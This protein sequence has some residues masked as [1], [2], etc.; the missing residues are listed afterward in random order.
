[1]QKR[2]ARCGAR[3]RAHRA[4]CVGPS[5]WHGRGTGALLAAGGS[6]PSLPRVSPGRA[7]P[8]RT[9]S[10]HLIWT[11]P[12]RREHPA[13]AGCR[14][15]AE[16]HLD[17]DFKKTKLKLTWLAQSDDCPAMELQ[18]GAAPVF[19]LSPWLHACRPLL[20]RARF[21]RRKRRPACAPPT[22]VQPAGGRRRSIPHPALPFVPSPLRLPSASL[23]S[24][25]ATW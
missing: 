12:V 2:T 13:P 8:Q 3:I 20:L 19:G 25:L 4:W 21:A 18:V 17:G 6:G 23:C 15:P 5:L 9:R 16:L 24:T 7:R 1:M 11:W 14:P 22:P 10:I